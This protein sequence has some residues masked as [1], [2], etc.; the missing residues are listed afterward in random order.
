[1][2]NYEWKENKVVDVIGNIGVASFILGFV[3]LVVILLFSLFGIISIDYGIVSFF[4]GMFLAIPFFLIAGRLST[5]DK[6]T[7]VF[8]AD[9]ENKLRNAKSK[10]D[11]INLKEFFENEAIG[12]SGKTYRLSFPADLKRLHQT[13]IDQIDILNKIEK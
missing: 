3:S 9:I 10:Q 6:Y 11:L 12:E 5:K 13:I 1:M 4:G 2:K 7:R 8:I